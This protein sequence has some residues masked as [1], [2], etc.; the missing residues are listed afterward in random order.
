MVSVAIRWSRDI[1]VS[2]IFGNKT[3]NV[4]MRTW[5]TPGEGNESFSEEISNDGFDLEYSLIFVSVNL[6][7]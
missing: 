1:Y 4:P 5:I 7:I 6:I 2:F 3:Y